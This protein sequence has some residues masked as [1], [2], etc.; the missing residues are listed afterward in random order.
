MWFSGNIMFVIP[1]W[2]YNEKSCIKF[3]NLKCKKNIFYNSLNQN[4][5][6]IF[7]DYEFF[8]KFKI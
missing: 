7:L 8:S 3:L 1:K 4:S 6:H 5:M 2:K